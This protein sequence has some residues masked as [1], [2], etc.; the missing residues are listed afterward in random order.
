[1]RLEKVSI[2]IETSSAVNLSEECPEQLSGIGPGSPSSPYEQP[3]QAT[4]D[5][6]YVELMEERYGIREEGIF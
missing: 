5:Q 4:P 1:M 6:V 2:A 3:A